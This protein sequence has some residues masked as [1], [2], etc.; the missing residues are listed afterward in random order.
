M[1]GPFASE[2]GVHTGDY[3]RALKRLNS[4]VRPFGGMAH[5][6]VFKKGTERVEFLL[7]S[8]GKAKLPPI[9]H[10]GGTNG[11]GSVSHTL[12]SVLQ[13]AGY[14]VGLHTSPH[15]FSVRERIRIQGRP[16]PKSE[17]V[18]WVDK[19]Y[20][21]WKNISASYFEV[22]TAI[23][24]LF[25]EEQELDIAII[26]VGLGG[27]WDATNLVTPLMSIISSIAYD[28]EDILGSTLQKIAMEKAGIIKPSIDVVLGELSP[29]VMPVMREVA[30]QQ[31]ASLH[32]NESFYV[33][34]VGT[35]ENGYRCVK[36]NGAPYELDIKGDFFLK[37]LPTICQ[38]LEVL[39]DKGFRTS[40]EAWKKGFRSVQTQTQLWGRWQE[41]ETQPLVICD[42]A[43]NGMAWQYV[44][45]QL[46]KMKKR[47]YV[48]LGISSD[49][50]RHYLWDTCPQEG[51][52]YIF[53]QS[54]QDRALDSN[55]LAA[56][57]SK[58]GLPHS[59]TQHVSLA[60]SE[61]RKRVGQDDFILITGSFYLVAEA[62]MLF[63]SQCK[64]D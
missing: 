28:H 42:V 20:P 61:A 36:I 54:V 57:A 22:C 10:V 16:I 46:K 51:V 60:L 6:S 32:T 34:D 26:E 5:S 21:Y 50:N 64:I 38:S 11:K 13:A 44:F 18:K 53:T 58:Y 52:H 3:P 63:T 49:K 56:E 1:S 43:H 25:F 31:G 55:I 39:K 40:S 62:L 8:L 14:K 2:G 27:R 9:V 41:M 47:G 37:N 59:Q 30:H 45:Q 35:K 33:E 12:A 17:F 15:F 19:S 24:L 23:A 48:I 4:L 29:E 7:N